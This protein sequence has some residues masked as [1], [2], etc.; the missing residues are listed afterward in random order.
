ML[1]SKIHRA[2]VTDANLE[3]VGSITVDSVLLEAAGILPFEQLRIANLSNG[4][5]FETYA[6][7]GEPESGT[8]CINGAAAH[9]AGRGDRIIIFQYVY[10]NEDEVATHT[11]KIVHVDQENRI[12][13]K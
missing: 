9:K 3:Y 1:K 4:E 2:T 12:I 11:P 8:I 10:L 6:M 7:A 5:R 13:R